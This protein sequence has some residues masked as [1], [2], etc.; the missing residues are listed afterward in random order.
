MVEDLKNLSLNDT[1]CKWTE[2]LA[3]DLDF[4]LKLGNQFKQEYK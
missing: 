1:I 3:T 4:I 2:I